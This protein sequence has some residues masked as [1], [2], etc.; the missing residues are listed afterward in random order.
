[1]VSWKDLEQYKRGG[2]LHLAPVHQW[3]RKRRPTVTTRPA[4]TS[5]PQA[6]QPLTATAGE[7]K[8]ATTIR[9]KWEYA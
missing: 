7:W 1:M 2:V 5:T 3:R 6:G 4:I 9:R 8:N